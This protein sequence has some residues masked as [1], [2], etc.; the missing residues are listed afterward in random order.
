MAKISTPLIALSAILT[1]GSLDA[2]AAG[3]AAR[4]SGKTTE[5]AAQIKAKRAEV[6]TK[7]AL[8]AARE[9]ATAYRAA[10]TTLSA[11]DEDLN[12]WVDVI[13][14]AYT[15]DNQGRVILEESY[16]F[17]EPEFLNR[18]TY[19]YNSDGMR[20]SSLEEISE[21]GGETW[22]PSSRY[23][24]TYDP[25]VTDF[26][27]ATLRYDWAGEW[28]LT[29]GTKYVVDRNKADV[30]TG[31]QRQANLDDEFHTIAR[32]TNTIG[33]DNKIEAYFNEEMQADETWEEYVDLRNIVW[34]KTN[35]QVV[36]FELDDLGMGAN[37][38]KS[39]E[40][41]YGGEIEGT[42]T[43]EYTDDYSGVLRI[44]FDKIP[45]EEDSMVEFERGL[46]PAGN[47]S[48][49]ESKKVSYYDEGELYEESEYLA[50]TYDEHS[51][52]LSELTVSDYDGDVFEFETLYDYTYSEEYGVPEQ[53]IISVKME[54]EEY[55]DTKITVDEFVGIAGMNVPTADDSAI[56]CTVAG[57]S[58]HISAPGASTTEILALD[59][60]SVASAAG[61]ENYSL[62]LDGIAAGFYI[63]RIATANSAKASKIAIR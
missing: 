12:D 19:T 52:I 4:F 20:T 2:D 48:Y 34:E 7:A 61:N 49:F 44:L 43:G 31:V 35:G 33:S 24:N 18:V 38:L 42:V 47:G 46:L 10:K 21:D 41:Y 56:R 53:T 14:L 45:G 59:G 8:Q 55:L 15:Y 32:I 27:T 28:E 17:E 37:R 11:W 51:N 62:K 58:V 6:R 26:K 50:I 30:V 22:E 13:S 23:D 9:Q 39:A 57:N 29:L 5:P 25:I 40:S 63:V 54:G 3:N 16:D 1:L 60:K 36:A